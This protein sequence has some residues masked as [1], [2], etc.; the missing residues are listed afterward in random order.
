MV[1]SSLIVVWP[2][3]VRIPESLPIK[4]VNCVILCTVCVWMCTILLPLGVNP[5]AVNRYINIIVFKIHDSIQKYTVTYHHQ[6]LLLLVEH[7]ASVKNFQA[8]RSPA[9]HL[10]SFHDLLVLLISSCIVLRHI[11]FGLPLLLY[12][13]RF[14]SN[15]VFSIAPASLRNV[16]PI[17]FHFL[18]FIWF[19]IDFWWVILVLCL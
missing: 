3:W 11:L 1:G 16:C 7:R 18:L 10:T 4:V 6:I 12:P 8:L 19:S 14:Q 15:A 13:W 5:N 17:Q 2:L 9:I